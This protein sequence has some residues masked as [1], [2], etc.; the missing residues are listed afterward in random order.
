MSLLNNG[1]RAEPCDELV[2]R[3]GLF[4]AFQQRSEEGRGVGTPQLRTVT[5]VHYIVKSSACFGSSR[6]SECFVSTSLHPGGWS[7]LAHRTA[8][9]GRLN[10]AQ[11][12]SSPRLRGKGPTA[13]WSKAERAG[14]PRFCREPP[15]STR[16]WVTSSSRQPGQGQ[17]PA[18]L[19]QGTQGPDRFHRGEAGDEQLVLAG[20]AS[21]PEAWPPEQ[22]GS[23]S[24]Y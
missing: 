8:R 12:I 1:L 17:H 24:C 4:F 22:P 11:Q 16:I 21:L 9:R 19:Q 5:H 3:P 13:F 6:R 14:H 18:K 23:T 7:F 10:R 20:C 15:V 2:A